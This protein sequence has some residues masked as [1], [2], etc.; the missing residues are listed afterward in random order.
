MSRA[1]AILALGL[2][3]V[4]TACAAKAPAPIVSAPRF[5]EFLPPPVPASAPPAVAADLQIAWNQLQAGNTGGADRTYDH[6]LKVAPGTVTTAGVWPQPDVF[7][8]L[9]VFALTTAIVFS[10]PPMIVT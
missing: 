3:L 4:A 7:L 10:V 9:H 5:P 1:L 2:S 6:V 8:A